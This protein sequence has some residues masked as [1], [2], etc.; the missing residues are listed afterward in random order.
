[1]TSLYRSNSAFVL[2]PERL[3]TVLAEI[4]RRL[5]GRVREAYIFGSAAT[6]TASADSD[7]DLILVK[8]EPGRPF[9]QRPLEFIDLYEV[10]PNL[11]ILVY[12]PRELDEQL[13]DS[14]LGFWKSVRFSMKRI[15]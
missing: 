8:D 1:M 3:E 12:T 13:L 6:G 15:V 14:A 7:I 5:Q 11:D 10:Y 4:T 2:S 9:I